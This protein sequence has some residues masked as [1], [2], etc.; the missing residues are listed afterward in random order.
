MKAT[1]RTENESVSRL[2]TATTT[3]S[4]TTS[5]PSSAESI[6]KDCEILQLLQC[7]P[8]VDHNFD[9]SPHPLEVSTYSAWLRYQ[10]EKREEIAKSRGHKYVMDDSVVE[11]MS[12][13]FFFKSVQKMDYAHI[14]LTEQ[15]MKAFVADYEAEVRKY[16]GICPFCLVKMNRKT[17]HAYAEKGRVGVD[18]TKCPCVRNLCVRCLC[19]APEKIGSGD[20]RREKGHWKVSDCSISPQRTFVGACYKCYSKFLYEGD[21]VRHGSPMHCPG[22]FV[23]EYVVA[24]YVFDGLLKDKVAPFTAFYTYI[25]QKDPV[26]NWYNCAILFYE[27]RNRRLSAHD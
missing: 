8:E 19:A 20:E 26:L 25:H 7:S 24:R 4:S 16:M 23:R 3:A 9:R 13:S 2:N 11:R 21:S 27:D 5:A 17:R 1:K 22:D 15:R 6:D 14:F 18:F 10:E 12:S